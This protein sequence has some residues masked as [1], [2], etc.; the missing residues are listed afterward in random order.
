MDRSIKIITAPSSE[1]VTATEVKLYTRVSSTVEDSL[2]NIWIKAGRLQAEWYQ[3]RSF[4]LQTLEIYYDDFPENVFTLPRPPLIEV[5]SIKYYDSGN[6]ETTLDSSVYDVDTSSTP[7]RIALSYGEIWPTTPLRSINGVI[8]NYNA[9]Y[10]SEASDV[11]ENVKDAIMLYC[12][13]RYE[14][15]IAEDGTVP[16][17]FYHLLQPDR[18]E[19]R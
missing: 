18:I 11:P 1:P 3:H 19:D 7:G 16:P 9:G 17:A 12:A 5:N 13:Y 14:N 6:N 2:I 15:R 8:V 10:G 4:I